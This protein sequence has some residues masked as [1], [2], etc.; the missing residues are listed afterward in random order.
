MIL[1]EHYTRDFDRNAYTIAPTKRYGGRGFLKSLIFVFFV[2][3]AP[4][5]N[6]YLVIVQK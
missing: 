6:E 2:T 4:R 1:G 3:F 5:L